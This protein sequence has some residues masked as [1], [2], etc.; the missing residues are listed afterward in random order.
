MAASHKSLQDTKD[1][2]EALMLLSN[3]APKTAVDKKEEAPV[4]SEIK[5][6]DRTDDFAVV[7]LW[8]SEA[9]SQSVAG[10]FAIDLDET[11]VNYDASLEAGKL[12]LIHEEKLRATLKYAIENKFLLTIATSRQFEKYNHFLSAYNIANTIAPGCFAMIFYTKGK[13]KLPALDYLEALYDVKP[14]LL[15]NEN[16]QLSAC[17]EY[18][19]TIPADMHDPKATYLDRCISFI[20]KKPIPMPIDFEDGEVLNSA[21]AATRTLRQ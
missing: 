3:S 21:P 13:S 2:L 14:C 19:Y 4:C 18:H 7:E 6:T 16:D 17:A 11:M 8:S 12:V 10:V 15:D 1:V 9:L 5:P 20:D